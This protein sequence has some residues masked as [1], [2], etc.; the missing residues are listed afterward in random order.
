MAYFLQLLFASFILSSA[1][2]LAGCSDEQRMDA[3]QAQTS[4]DQMEILKY[5]GYVTAANVSSGAFGKA[6]E[7]HVQTVSKQLQDDGPIERYDVVP[8]HQVTNIKRKLDEAVARQGSIPELDGPARDYA[9]AVAAFEPVNNGLSNYAA[10]KGYLADGGKKAREEDGKF[11][12]SL[13]K[14]SD[15]EATF[16]DNIEKRDERLTREA[17]E[18]AP[19]GSLERYRLGAVIH[20][21]AAM[22]KADT[23]FLSP[24]D[25][26]SRSQFASSLNE[27]ATMVEG[28]DTKI[29]EKKP[30]GCPAL[31]GNFNSVIAGGRKALQNAEQGR[32]MVSSNADS[33]MMQY[34]YNSLRGN[35][36]MMISNLNAPHI[37]S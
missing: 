24:D 36:A 19:A 10:S 23:I 15:A 4:T 22:K 8:V 5:N 30:E 11:V 27:M 21:K 9:A 33:V 26:E 7:Q 34:E 1:L 17:Y 35:F 25:A 37:C 3:G 29:R 18:K 31:Q 13:Q 28:W 32:Y 16:F 12:E 2:A 20:A 14:V 6:L